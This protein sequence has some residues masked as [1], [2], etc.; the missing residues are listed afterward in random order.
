MQTLL[1]LKHGEFTAELAPH[2]GGA[3]ASFYSG[4]GEPGASARRD[5]LRPATPEVLAARDPLR[6][7]SFPLVPWC[8]RIRDGRFDWE[9]R[10]VRLAPN[11][12]A[13]PHTIHG[14]GWQ[15]SWEVVEATAASAALRFECDGRGAWPFAFHCRQRYALDDAGLAIELTLVN[16]GP[17][18]MPAGLGHHPFFPH[19]REGAGT[20]VQA[21]VDA[22]WENDDEQ[23]PTVLSATD[24]ALAA[25][26]DG[27]R[28]D[29]FALD[30]NFTGF[31][32][33][34]QVRWPDGSALTLRGDGPL[35]YFVL[36]SPRDQDL[37]VME[38][39]SNCTDWINLR[40]RDP[41]LPV[42]GTALAPGDTL[43]AT[44]RFGEIVAP[45]G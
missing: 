43:R 34:A 10:T 6:M 18:S 15:R 36:Y 28:L 41:A 31:G 12:G 29:R 30:N 42:G 11:F 35:D 8:N 33:S 19:R 9:G 21:Q 20:V 27:M 7:A 37:F 25:L 32:H 23:M 38:A 16:T 22:M 26:R 17:R 3:L 24:P 44:W 5:W 2:L 4:G 40:A 45:R 13:S 39:V 14:L 1:T